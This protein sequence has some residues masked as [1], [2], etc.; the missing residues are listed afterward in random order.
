MTLW[1]LSELFPP[2]ETSTA[3][4]MGEIANAFAGK[5]AV[6][7]ICGP[8]V[9]DKRKRTDARSKFHLDESIEVLHNEIPALDKN[10]FIGKALRFILVSRKMMRCVRKNVKDGD[11]VLMVTN[12]APLVLKVSRFRR[13][14]EFELN[15]LVHDVFPE[16]T[17]PAGLKLPKS[18]YSYAK[19]LFDK[20]YRR[21]DRLIALGRDMKEVLAGKTGREDNI[22]I[23]GNW[24]DTD[25]IDAS[26]VPDHGTIRL[27]YAG[28]I[29]RVQGLDK[30]VDNLPEGVDFHLYGTGAMESRLKEM[31]HPRVSFHGAYLRSEQNEILRDCDI[32]LVALQDGMFG[33]GVPS[34]TYNILA[35][36][37]PVLFLGP[38]GSEIYRLVKEEGVGYC[39]WPSEFN[40]EELRQM[41][42]RAREIAVRDYSKEII[43][44]KF[45]NLI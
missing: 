39:G 18:I 9:Y 38:E 5:Y 1:I 11:K 27:Q 34:K 29:G 26:D 16:N 40:R 42:R 32:A 41:G 15:I 10:T 28:N 8:E 23:I 17:V 19:R 13:T 44:Q 20:A 3:F 4:I 14:R 43:L 35:A 25:I 37:R 7:V 22:F 24:A 33:L 36:G 12:P 21:A 2:D 45:L 6:K 31:H 30:V